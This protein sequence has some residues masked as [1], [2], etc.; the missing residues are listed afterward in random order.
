MNDTRERII[1]SSKILIA[2]YGYAHLTLGTITKYMNISKGVINYH[3]PQ[4]DM[5]FEEIMNE[6]QQKTKAFENQDLKTAIS[7][8]LHFIKDH[9]LLYLASR[10]IYLNHRDKD[11][12]LVYIRYHKDI[13]HIVICNLIESIGYEI[14]LGNKIDIENSIQQIIDIIYHIKGG[15]SDESNNGR[16]I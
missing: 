1:E 7:S 3:F 2:R 9:Q 8:Y 14:A 10:D 4:K 5:V 13:N 6:Y 15:I 16:N 12:K 11:G